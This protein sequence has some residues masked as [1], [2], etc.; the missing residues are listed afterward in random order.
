VKRAA[1]LSPARE[2]PRRTKVPQLWGVRALASRWNAPRESLYRA[3]KRGDLPAV[4]I[5]GTLKVTEDDALSYL[6]R[7]PRVGGGA[8]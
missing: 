4:R 1:T 7:C 3:I 5:L 6:A 2:E 8:S